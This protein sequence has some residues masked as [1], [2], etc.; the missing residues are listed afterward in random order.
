[1]VRLMSVFGKIQ[2]LIMVIIE[3]IV[4]GVGQNVFSIPDNSDNGVDRIENRP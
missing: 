1:M 2:S 3:W 4:V